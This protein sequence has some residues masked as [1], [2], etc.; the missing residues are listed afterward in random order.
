MKK[1]WLNAGGYYNPLLKWLR[2]MK[3][4]LF[5]LLITLVH[6]SASVYSQQTRLSI[7][8]NNISVREVLRDIEDQS[9]FFFLYKNEDINVD[10]I[11]SVNMKDKSLEELLGILFKGTD[12]SYKIHGR[13]IVLV[14]D[15]PQEQKKI[16]VA[17]KVTDSSGASL[18]GVTVLVKGTSQ[19]IVTNFDGKYLLSNV[20]SEGTL[21]FSFVGMRAKEIEVSGRTTIDVKLEEETFGIDEV[22][23]IGYGSIKKRDLTGSVSSI[24][25]EDIQKTNPVGVNQALQGKLAGVQVQQAD[26]A[27]GAGVNILIRGANSFTTSTEPLY[28]VDGIPFSAGEAPAPS[29]F[30]D[31]QRNNPLSLINTKDIASIEVL[32]DASAT[33]IYGSR[34]A[35]GVVLITTKGGRSKAHI[36]FNTNFGVSQ[37]VKQIEVLDAASYAEYRNEM[38]INGYTY[39]GKDYVADNNL[40]Y[41]IPGRWSYTK[42][43]DGTTGLETIADSTYL[44][45]PDDYRNGYMGGGTNWQDQIYQTA[46][47]SDYN[48]SLSGGDEKGHYMFSGSYLDQQ[49]VIFNSYYKRYT[50]RSNISRKIS[51]RIEVGNNLS[52]TKSINRLARTN[53]ESYGVIPSAI[54][55][56][57]TRE[58]FDPTKDSGYT[59][60]TSTGLA[61]PYLYTRTAK[62]QV[63][64]LNIFTSAFAEIK[65]T[66]YLKFRQNLGYGYN[67]NTRNEYYNRWVA[68]GIAPTNGYGVQADN[69]YESMTLESMLKFNKKIAEIHQIDAVVAWTHEKVNYGGKSMSAKGF[70]N[71]LTEE[72]DMN[73]ALNQDRNT[74]SKGMSSLMS[75]LGRVNYVLLEKYMF[76]A[77][78]R[79]DG[80]SRFSETNRWS[81][82]SSF[83]LAWR[84]SDE[85]FI[86]NLNFFDALKLRA[87]YGQ[88][89]N[90]GI[91]AYATRSRMTAQNYPFNGNLN[92]GF[93]ED[94][95]GGPANP[96]LKWETTTQ[97]DVG[98]DVSILKNRINLVVDLYYKKTDDLLQNMFIPSS[99]G[100]SSMASNYGNIENKGLEIAGNFIVASQANFSWKIDANISFNRNKVSGLEAD[101][102]SDVAWGMESMFLRRNGE[103]IGLIYGYQEDGFFDNEAEVRSNPL[104]KN[105]SDA[106]IKSM[107]GQVKYK[108]NDKNGVIDDRDKA[109]IGNTNPNFTYG[110]T[111]SFQ[112]KNISVNFFLQGTS[113]NDILNVNIKRYDLAGT[114]NI[115]RFIYDNR[116]TETNRENATAPR[117]DGTYTRSMK[118]SDRY[119]DNG[120]YLR[121]K[122]LN[123]G[124]MFKNPFQFVQSLN[125]SA[126]VT[127]LFT[128][129]KYKWYDPDVN[130]FGGDPARRGVDMASYPSARTISLGLQLI[131]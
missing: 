47:T 60:D 30:G 52:F 105:E 87:S 120:S 69:H 72:N 96:K 116:W 57:P 117:P 115:P 48:L 73:A 88:T 23:A 79:R 36:E 131:F 99:T 61:N 98:L 130:T 56:N 4:T 42:I 35:N 66:D 15:V 95:W 92:S 94:R 118:A 84:L 65:F 11:V 45:S 37:I 28:V 46:V 12:V 80:S 22:V 85:P 70:P 17:G 121:M 104:Y 86:K 71:D 97:G 110:V 27:P 82:F 109:I 8:A 74:S 32:K 18:P 113:G 89:G 59:E 43:K 26:G 58:V 55:F 129:T 20:P 54:A 128:I 50:V 9:E 111:N 13:Q 24:R 90:Q 67:S 107:I 119:V 10:R 114:G 2:I 49:G 76:T 53:S 77:S 63:G 62:N 123:V 83:A 38:V 112:I 25:V 40:P 6:V 91:S 21:I 44:P 75:Y 126:S 19:G 106:K 102:F 34:A 51:D 68:E 93:A 33:A 41:P 122:N 101:Q 125:V 108:D 14:N 81:N 1:K 29:A 39:D 16:T 31:K 100:F 127:N 103:P 3:L 124:Y 78:F 5:V 7:S 64:S